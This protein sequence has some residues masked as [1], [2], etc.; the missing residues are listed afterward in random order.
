[1]S[2][3]STTPLTGQSAQ[4]KSNRP[5]FAARL[6]KFWAKQSTRTILSVYAVLLVLLFSA[7]F[8]SESF[9]PVSLAKTVVA[10]AVFS[11]VVAFGQYLVVLTGGLDLSIPSVMTLS[12]VVLT[13]ETLGLD[14]K[15][16]YIVP[17]VL[18]LGGLIG[19]VNG[20]GIVYAAISPV[21]MTLAVNVIIG[22]AV[23]VYTNGTPSGTAPPFLVSLTQSKT[24][25]SFPTIGV[26]LAVFVVIAI[27]AVG[28][29][30]F[31]RQVYAIGSNPRVAYL[32]GVS[33]N[34]L[35]LAVYSISGMTAAIG[36]MLL[37]GY[38]GQSYLTLGDPYLLLSLAAVILGGVAIT[39]GRGSYIGVVGGALILITISVVLSGTSLPQ[40]F[41]QIIYAVVII[42]AVLTARQGSTEA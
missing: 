18:V 14:S 13:A 11:A 33:V 12:G 28:R 31:G 34:R 5:R 30:A 19:L 26:F 38:S 15:A 2:N 42:A 10:L 3:R 29:T 36:G 7:R 9:G 37:T 40:S 27:F 1:M 16:V 41:R 32:S 22:G 23:L 4:N 6:K 35:T 20:L 24:G 25:G 39:G 21:V 8:V 17:L